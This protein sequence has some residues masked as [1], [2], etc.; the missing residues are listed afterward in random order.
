MATIKRKRTPDNSP[1]KPKKAFVSNA[2]AVTFK[3]PAICEPLKHSRVQ[4]DSTHNNNK[5][6]SKVSPCS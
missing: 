2:R 3:N 5:Y 6:E 4:H 1:H